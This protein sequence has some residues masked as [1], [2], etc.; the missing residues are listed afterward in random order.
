MAGVV[1]LSDGRWLSGT[2][3]EQETASRCFSQLDAHV[4]G[5]PAWPIVTAPSEE[6]DVVP[7][8]AGSLASCAKSCVPA[9]DLGRD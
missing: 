8:G 2:G 5:E 1:S 4:V 7:C 6:A 3:C 9:A